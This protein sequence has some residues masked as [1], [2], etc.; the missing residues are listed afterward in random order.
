MMKLRNTDKHKGPYC[1]PG[2]LQGQGRVCS[3]SANTDGKRR[4]FDG[5]QQ[6]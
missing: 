3:T 2:D 5:L 4:E 1:N 6:L